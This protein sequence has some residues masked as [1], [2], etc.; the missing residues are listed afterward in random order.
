MIQLRLSNFA[1]FLILFLRDLR[2][3]SGVE[4]SVWISAK[5]SDERYGFLV[6]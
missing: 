3:E 1:D 2:S 5:V 4:G 6:F